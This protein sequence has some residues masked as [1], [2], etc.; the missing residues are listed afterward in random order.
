MQI[1]P[2]LSAASAASI[3]AQSNSK[4]VST[5]SGAGNASTTA[6]S[7]DVE[8]SQESNDDRDAQGQG[9]GLADRGQK[10]QSEVEAQIAPNDKKPPASAPTLPGEPPSRLDVIG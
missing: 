4:D 8:Q 7:A 9:D 5:A 6:L 3:A 1:Q 2:P 10:K